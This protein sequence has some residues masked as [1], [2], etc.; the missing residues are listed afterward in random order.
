MRRTQ[1]PLGP[2]GAAGTLAAGRGAKDFNTPLRG[3]SFVGDPL[4]EQGSI[5][6]GLPSRR[7]NP[8]VSQAGNAGKARNRE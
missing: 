3:S 7:K 1:N 4:G 8:Q 6:L 2:P 5:P